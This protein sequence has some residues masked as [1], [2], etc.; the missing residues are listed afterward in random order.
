MAHPLHSSFAQAEFLLGYAPS[1]PYLKPSKI[2]G[3]ENMARHLPRVLEEDSLEKTEPATTAR[4]EHLLDWSVVHVECTAS[5]CFAC[6]PSELRP[7]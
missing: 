4:I 5:D 6:C 1:I 3:S 2:I 7:G